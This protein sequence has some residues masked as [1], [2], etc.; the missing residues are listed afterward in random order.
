VVKNRTYLFR[1]NFRQTPLARLQFLLLLL[2]LVG[3]RALNREWSGALGVLE[4]L[5]KLLRG[6]A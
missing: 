5:G 4:G 1:K 6:K 3:H 2:K